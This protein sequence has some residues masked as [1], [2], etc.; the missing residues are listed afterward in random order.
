MLLHL[1]F[2]LVL[3]HA[4]VSVR[5]AHFRAGWADLGDAPVADVPPAPEGPAA[6]LPPPEDD[7]GVGDEHNPVAHMA[8]TRRAYALYASRYEGGELAYFIGDYANDKP[9]AG[10]NTVVAGSYEEDKPFE[11]P[12]HEAVPQMRHFWDYRKGDS[13]GLMG[14]D[15][16]VDRSQKYWTGGFGLDGAYDRG[17]GKKGVKGMGVLGLY[18]KGDKGT[19]YWYLGHVAHLLQDLTVP[20]HALLWPHP[21]HLDKYEGF[22][23]KNH[24][25]W[26]RTPPGPFETFGS[27]YE[28]F[29]KTAEI[30]AGFDAGT[31]PG[32]LHGKDGTSDRGRRRAAKFPEELLIEE[33]DVLMPLAVRRVAALFVLFFKQIDQNPPKADL[34]LERSGATVTLRVSASDGQSGVDREGFVYEW[35]RKDGATWSPWRVLASAEFRAGSPGLYRFRASARDAAG[36]VGVSG[37]REVRVTVPLLAES[38]WGLSPKKYGVDPVTNKVVNKTKFDAKYGQGA[39]DKW[40]T[41][42]GDLD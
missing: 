3:A 39:A 20:A 36:N 32:A 2:P 9:P 37:V 38:I 40:N 33:G 19:A 18:R 22:A 17:W 15:S 41:E 30:T 16:S 31:A 5:D 35:S 14:H 12:W 11:N 28:T 26:E 8:I 29:R 25:R 1:V 13:A 34:R 23:R 4:S 21:L 24:Q 27:L 42:H 10:R 7:G 6:P